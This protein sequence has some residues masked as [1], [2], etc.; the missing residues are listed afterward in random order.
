MSLSRKLSLIV[1]IVVLVGVLILAVISN[2]Y[3][4]NLLS[5]REEEAGLLL[6]QSVLS[7]LDSEVDAIKIAVEVIANDP[8]TQRLF[9]ERDREGLLELYSARYDLLKDDIYQFQ[10]HLPD[11][12]FF[13]AAQPGKVRGQSL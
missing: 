4:T 3:T 12:T 13:A 5:E 10:F 7:A 2:T 6:G 8:E 11:S 1:S 9:Y